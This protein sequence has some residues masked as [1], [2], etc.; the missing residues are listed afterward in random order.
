MRGPEVARLRASASSDRDHMVERVGAV[1]AAQPA[2]RALEADGGHEAPIPA[3]AV[4]GAH[5]LSASTATTSAANPR[6]NA[7]SSGGRCGLARDELDERRHDG[8]GALIVGH[9]LDLE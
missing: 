4:G 3:G 8:G 2:R 7:G 1:V 9:G 6:R 5:E